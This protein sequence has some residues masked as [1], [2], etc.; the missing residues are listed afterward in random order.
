MDPAIYA[1]LHD[2]GTFPGHSQDLVRRPNGIVITDPFLHC[3]PGGD[4]WLC[5]DCGCINYTPLMAVSP[6]N[7]FSFLPYARC[8]KCHEGYPGLP[9]GLTTLFPGV[10]MIAAMEREAPRLRWWKCCVCSGR[11]EMPRGGIKSAREFYEQPRLC[12]CTHSVAFNMPRDADHPAQF[13]PAHRPCWGC[14]WNSKPLRA[15]G[16]G[17][18]VLLEHW[19]QNERDQ[20][21]NLDHEK[22]GNLGGGI[23]RRV[24]GGVSGVGGLYVS[25]REDVG[26]VVVGGVADVATSD[27]N[28]RA[29]QSNFERYVSQQFVPRGFGDDPFWKCC[30]CGKRRTLPRWVRDVRAEALDVLPWTICDGVVNGEAGGHA[31]VATCCHVLC[32]LCDAVQ[33]LTRFTPI[34][35]I[36][37][38]DAVR[39]CRCYTWRARPSWNG[40]KDLKSFWREPH[41]GV[42][43]T[44]VCRGP[45]KPW[46]TCGHHTC[47]QCWWSG[48][49]S[50]MRTKHFRDTRN[51]PGFSIT[52]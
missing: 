45:G 27:D 51:L 40:V 29:V 21:N 1:F 39:C 15:A 3:A 33:P 5:K 32:D 50:W 20:V 7:P 14:D 19:I 23:S 11:V 16:G 17:V 8:H 48:S 44:P 24:V 13:E 6:S 31:D 18:D 4:R 2:L 41:A 47:W 49:T 37:A 36:T 46:G 9:P 26:V 38:P 34:E 43:F 52:K 42:C 12:L 10:M 35:S 28:A 25:C 30:R 22:L